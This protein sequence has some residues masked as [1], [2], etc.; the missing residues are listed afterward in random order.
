[1]IIN[2]EDVKKI[3]PKY[4]YI[5][6]DCYSISHIGQ[7]LRLSNNYYLVNINIKSDLLS[8]S[9]T[10]YI[11]TNKYRSIDKKDYTLI[12]DIRRKEANKEAQ[13]AIRRKKIAVLAE[14]FKNDPVKL[15]L[16]NKIAKDLKT[17][18]K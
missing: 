16:L 14:S 1:M 15:S 5:E 13:Y 4:W 10:T 12:N 17:L 11:T 18:E 9:M 7:I 6:R 2:I 3:I 8:I